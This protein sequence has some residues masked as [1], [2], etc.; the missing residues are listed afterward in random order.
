MLSIV[1]GIGLFLL[2]MVLL[3]DG[4][5]AA[6][7]DALRRLLTH[8]TGGRVKSLISGVAITALVQ[9]SSATTLMTIGFVSA[10]LLTFPQAIGVIFGANL[11]TTSTGW[12]VSLLGLKLSIGIVALPLVAV[13]ALLRLLGRGRSGAVGLAAAGFGLIFV[14]IDML[15]V[16]MAD[17]ALHV[18]PARLPGSTAAGRLLLVGAGLVMTVVMQS[19]S[20]ALA[21]TLTALA[22]GT[23]D[24]QQGAALVIGQNV[25]TTVTAGLAA[26]GASVPA[27]RTA[28]AHVLFNVLTAV[29]AFGVLPVLLR[30]AYGILGP[31]AGSSPT[32]LA[33]FHTIFKVL[34]VAILLPV[35][36][37]FSRL[38]ERMIPDRGPV[39]TRHLDVSV[40]SLPP[41]AVEAA[42]RTL[43]DVLHVAAAAAAERL[44]GDGGPSRLARIEASARALEEVRGFMAQVRSAPDAPAAYGRHVAT[45]HV[46]DHLQRFLDASEDAAGRPV[47]GDARLVEAARILSRAF[48]LVAGWTDLEE[49]APAGDL[50]ALSAALTTPRDEHRR[51]LLE[52]TARG[53]VSPAE[54]SRLLER[55]RWIDRLA[56]HLWR[57][58]HHLSGAPSVET[59]ISDAP[60]EPPDRDMTS[61]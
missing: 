28:L 52:L 25:G 47:N 12:I 36:P 35:V 9:S 29:V 16:G 40:T 41:V 55:M 45:L 10:G 49:Q 14:G 60:E 32:T 27:K 20:A 30:A 42:R 19:S 33:A 6:A 7:G 15:Q 4:L 46:V 61:L 1:G 43:F 48:A 17:L 56:Y 54:A 53:D 22:S 3:T 2:G 8:F 26:I 24:L 23:I 58:V 38:I 21:T 11:G 5:K 18:E 37:R 57:A 31:G 50:A 34:G 59:S 13:G 51:E 44:A 39:L